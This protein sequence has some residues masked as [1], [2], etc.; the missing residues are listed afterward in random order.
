[1]LLGLNDPSLLYRE[2]FSP[3]FVIKKQG[4]KQFERIEGAYP[5]FGQVFLFLLAVCKDC[6]F[7]NYLK[8]RVWCKPTSI[9]KQD[10]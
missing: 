2:L 3:V 10:R 9:K 6:C 1:M 5:K 4:A 7:Y 8:L